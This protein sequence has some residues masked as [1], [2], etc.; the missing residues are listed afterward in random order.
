MPAADLNEIRGKIGE[1]SYHELNLAQSQV[2]RDRNNARANRDYDR[3]RLCKDL[4]R[5]IDKLRHS[6]VRMTDTR[7][8]PQQQRP[9]PP[10][11]PTTVAKPST[12]AKPGK[13]IPA[14]KVLQRITDGVQ[15]EQPASAEA[16]EA[17]PEAEQRSES[18]GEG[19]EVRPVFRT[20]KILNAHTVPQL[21][22][23]CDAAGLRAGGAK[24]ELVARLM[25]EEI[26]A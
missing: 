24:G 17:P 5:D 19:V 4:M 10:A 7:L 26:T 3:I 25:S 20:V 14:P 13:P 2:E 1:M 6:P 21:R 11:K 12:P 9:T 23:M 8:P 22:Q 18:T 15:G 16:E